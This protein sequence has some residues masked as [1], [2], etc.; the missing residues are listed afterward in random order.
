MVR[1]DAS[2]YQVPVPHIETWK[3]LWIHQVVFRIPGAGLRQEVRFL[4]QRLRHGWCLQPFFGRLLNKDQFTCRKWCEWAHCILSHPESLQGWTFLLARVLKLFVISRRSGPCDTENH[5]TCAWCSHRFLEQPALK[6]LFVSMVHRM[7]EALD[8]KPSISRTGYSTKVYKDVQSVYIVATWEAFLNCVLEP[9]P[10]GNLLELATWFSWRKVTETFAYIYIVLQ[11]ILWMYSCQYTCCKATLCLI[12]P[13]AA[14]MTPMILVSP[15]SWMLSPPAHWPGWSLSMP[16]QHRFTCGR[17][18]DWLW[19]GGHAPQNGWSKQ[20]E[21]SKDATCTYNTHKDVIKSYRIRNLEADM[22][23]YGDPSQE[24]EC[25]PCLQTHN[26]L[27]VFLRYWL[28]VNNY[29]TRTAIRC[30]LVPFADPSSSLWA[31]AVCFFF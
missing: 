25:F 3:S 22:H 2:R 21:H 9:G 16:S 14:S 8:A 28:A 12:L 17:V 20:A 1:G 6:F 30:R 7:R 5:E 24:S 18:C 15:F 23:I 19:T 31:F 10:P 26:H 11:E 4:R 27:E 13:H 29:C